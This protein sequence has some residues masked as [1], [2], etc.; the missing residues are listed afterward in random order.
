M[1]QARSFGGYSIYLKKNF[2]SNCQ[3]L[4]TDIYLPSIKDIPK[5]PEH[6][7][8][9][10]FLVKSNLHFVLKPAIGPAQAQEDHCGPSTRSLKS[11]NPSKSLSRATGA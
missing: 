3:C 6:P 5:D 9:T 7:S 2:Q 11:S 4:S 8:P 1:Y 10:Y